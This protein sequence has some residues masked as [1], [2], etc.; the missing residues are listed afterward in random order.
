MKF[1]VPNAIRIEPRK[2]STPPSRNRCP[3]CSNHIKALF[4][5]FDVKIKRQDIEQDNRIKKNQW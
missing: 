1:D 3:K 5:P 2:D 4:H